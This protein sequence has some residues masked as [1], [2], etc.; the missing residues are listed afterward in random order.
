MDPD[1][2][3][4]RWDEE[5][6]KGRYSTEPPLPFVTEIVS[7]LERRHSHAVDSGLYVGC[8][9]G[10]NFLPLLDAGLNL[11]GLDS[12]SEALRTLA[13]RRPAIA[14]RLICGDFRR[15]QASR[16]FGYL[17]AIQ[18]FQ[19]GT[20]SDAETYF[21]KSVELLDPGGVLFARVNST[22]T[23]IYYRHTVIETTGLGGLTVRYDEGPK[24]GLA[25]HFYSRAELDALTH[26]ALRPLIEPREDIIRRRPPQTG[27][28][29]QWEMIWEKR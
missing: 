28:W 11:Y 16:P 10:R 26:D 22:R 1:L 7:T 2:T 24:Q 13:D 21:R 29:A 9:N 25:I 18:V 12:S 20:A 3:A 4:A 17:V 14:A 15:F 19:H 27:H 6:R 23:Q 8:G 5:Y